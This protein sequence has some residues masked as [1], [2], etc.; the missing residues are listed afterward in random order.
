MG[1]EGWGKEISWGQE[2]AI[3]PHWRTVQ[4]KDGSYTR[5][6]CPSTTGTVV[7][8]GIGDSLVVQ[9]NRCEYIERQPR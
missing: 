4:N 1:K 7:G 9:C 2:R 6:E 3:K 5:E 8:T